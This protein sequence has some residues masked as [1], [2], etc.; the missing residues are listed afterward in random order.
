MSARL[1]EKRWHPLAH[2][3]YS[4]AKTRKD[5]TAKAITKTP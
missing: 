2:W 1:L 5:R 4:V 3:I